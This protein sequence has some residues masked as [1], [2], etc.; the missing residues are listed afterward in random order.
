MLGFLCS[1]KEDPSPA[2]HSDFNV[3]T[4]GPTALRLSPTW[5]AQ[6]MTFRS[7]QVRSPVCR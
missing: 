3:G 2:P 1:T 7:L 4:P 6:K 5:R